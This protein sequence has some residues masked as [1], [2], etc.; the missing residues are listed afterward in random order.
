MGRPVF[1]RQRIRT[2]AAS[3][4]AKS[5][6]EFLASE[7]RQRREL[8]PEEALL[9]ARDA[10]DYLSTHLLT[11]GPGQIEL[12]AIAGR[13]THVRRR[14]H[15]QP[16][17]LVTLTVLAEEDA[18]VLAEW[19][20]TAMVTSRLARVIEEAYAQD[21]LLDATRLCL[22]V[23][24]SIPAI[25][26]RLRP[27][28]EQGATLPIAGMPR[29]VRAQ[30]RGLRGALALERYLG[31]EDLTRI[32]HDLRVSY[33]LWLRW[34]RGF[35]LAVQDPDQPAGEVAR[36]L[37]QPEELVVAWRQLWTRFRDR[38]GVRERLAA[39]A[40]AGEPALAAPAVTPGETF[41]RLLLERH[42]YTPAAAE[43]F[44]LDLQDLAARLNQHAR[45]SGQVLYFGV[46]SDE[47]PGRSLASSRLLPVVLDYVTPEDW[48]RVHRD[49]SSDLKWERLQR[50]ATQA[51]A[52]GVALSLPDL[53]FLL[54]LSTDAI[55][56]CLA[57]HPQVV[58]PTRGRVADMGPTLSH[59][60][61]II[62]LYMDGYTET[63]IK[64]RTGH[65]YESIER[66]LLDF[67][68]VV[69]LVEAGMPVPAIRQAVAR[70]R[71]VVEKYVSLYQRFS[72]PDYR[73][74]MGQIR[75]LAHAHPTPPRP[76][77]E[78]GKGFQ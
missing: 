55:Q 62:G 37:G 15:D 78:R 11:R 27:L 51:Y 31:G 4:E 52:Q 12:P 45:S 5:L 2:Q 28:W 73:W 50:L 19:G 61:K 53:S 60:E 63:E 16:E 18:A 22:L 49:R 56:H 76:K 36:R 33:A 46:A 24:L 17:R 25:R 47:P 30:F 9:L 6:L 7:V 41:Y 29:A 67:A 59:A 68:R 58:L 40:P 32:R 69:V 70:S 26:D 64:R 20:L 71:R 57:E 23:P 65:S 77:S 48:S 75:R 1:Y 35:R 34:W 66:Y 3:I 14:R 43:Q 10:Y 44:L 54:G 72:H 21:A 42:H 8:A 74:R 13:H 38:P 39:A